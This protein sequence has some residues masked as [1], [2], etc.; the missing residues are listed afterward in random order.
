MGSMNDTSRRRRRPVSSPGLR[1]APLAALVL[2]VALLAWAVPAGPAPAA[3]ND[4]YVWSVSAI[5][6][7]A[8]VNLYSISAGASND[9]W[10]AANAPGP[11]GGRVYHYDGTAWSRLLEGLAPVFGISA[12][13]PAHVW[14]VGVSGTIRFYD[15]AAW[16]D[17]SVGAA[18]TLNAVFALDPANVWA[19]GQGGTVKFF[20]GTAWRDR[21]IAGAPE[22]KSV[23]ALDV[24]H[25]WAT[26]VNGTVYAWDGGSWKGGAIG[27]ANTMWSLSAVDTNCAWAVGQGGTVKFFD[28]SAWTNAAVPGVSGTFYSVSALDVN[29]VFASSASGL[30]CF[31]DGASWKTLPTGAG[32]SLN[33]L[34]VLD[35]DHVFAVGDAGTFVWGYSTLSAQASTFYFAEGTCRP[36]FDPYL[37][38]QNPDDAVAASVR[39][40]YML[41]TGRTVPQTLTVAPRSRATVAVK[42]VLGSGD[43]P[44]HDFSAKVECVNEV[45]IVAERPMYFSYRSSQGTV[46]TG[47]SDVV[48][49]LEPRATFYFAE[50]TCRP[51][52]DPYLC[53]QNPNA[54]VS[55]VSIRFMLGNGRASDHDMTVPAHSRKTVAVRQLLGTG[56][57]P[58]HDFSARVATTD[59]TRIVAERPMYFSY[60]SSQGVTITGGHD[61]VGAPAPSRRFY[62]AEGTCRPDFDPYICVQNPGQGAAQ[63]RITYMLGN[64][65][66]RRQDIG[67]PAGSRRTVVVRDFLGTGDDPAHD[68]SAVLET[69]NGTRIVAE[70]PMYFNYRST[71]G[72]RLTGGH[73]VIGATYP[74]GVFYFAE[75]S[76]RPGFDSYLCV[77]NPG[78]VEVGIMIT[79]MVG[80]GPPREQRLAVPARSRRTVSVKDF[81]GSGDD[82][83]HD[84]SARVSA[85][86]ADIN[87]V[88]VE[89]PV[90]FDY[91]G[92]SGASL[93]GGHDVV[94]YAP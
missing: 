56:D 6:D 21:S 10:V 75:G 53:I 18:G 26:G 34:A 77:Q 58:A 46:I 40:T 51:G 81:L 70:R 38:I 59:G 79:Y 68:F 55:R 94:G 69:L 23:F 29:H 43:D 13:D 16:H 42:S 7:G 90:Y 85:G 87:E 78:A 66:E 52:F 62:F 19:V 45:P 57:D 8:T 61:V 36:S 50:G 63:V 48:G 76:C 28:G 83:A 15:G 37:C 17:Q 4:P 73:D 11:T 74:S 44:A 31:W 91:R 64:G 92:T 25:A 20:D 93:T 65:E 84:F 86:L 67:V 12:L 9:V 47:G 72:A 49:A 60:T 5:P 24:G 54:V 89:R 39:V 3:I 35:T 41:G 1:R 22:L 2:A 80:S 71:G 82:A 32:T 27:G 33:S 14:V 88:V 30:I